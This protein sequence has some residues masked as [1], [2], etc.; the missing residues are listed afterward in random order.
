MCSAQRCV[1]P[2][3]FPVDLLY[4]VS[5]KSTAPLCSG[6]F[7][8]EKRNGYQYLNDKPKNSLE[9]FIKTEFAYK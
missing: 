5:N 9:I 8:L 4:Y 1:L 6:V 2:V 3:S 7:S